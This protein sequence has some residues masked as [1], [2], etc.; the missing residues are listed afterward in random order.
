MEELKPVTGI[1]LIDKTNE[2]NNLYCSQSVSEI[3]EGFNNI[4]FISPP[5]ELFSV[6]AFP[7]PFFDG[8]AQEIENK[9]AL[10]TASYPFNTTSSVRFKWNLPGVYLKGEKTGEESC[11]VGNVSNLSGLYFKGGVSEIELKNKEDES[12]KKITDYQAIFHQFENF[13]EA[14]QIFSESSNNISIQPLSATVFQRRVYDSPDI[15][16]SG[17]PRVILYPAPNYKEILN[18]DG[19]TA[20]SQQVFIGEI[21]SPEKIRDELL[22]K[23]CSI[24]VPSGFLVILF[25][26]E[27]KDGKNPYSFYRCQVFTKDYPDLSKEIGRASCRERV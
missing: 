1:Y 20:I 26:K 9:G 14:C 17:T 5:E 21:P 16:T 27:P 19:S 7:K 22:N 2:E 4:Q 8:D 18:D 23:V 24:R 10:N 13:E 11:L 25:E 15:P 3:P 6:F 12:G